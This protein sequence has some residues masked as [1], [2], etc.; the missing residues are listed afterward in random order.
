MLIDSP[1]ILDRSDEREASVD[2]A[3]KYRLSQRAVMTTIATA[4][5]TGAAEHATG[6]NSRW[7]CGA[8]S[9]LS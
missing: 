4:P 5:G 1:R 6:D 7:H 9:C 2:A 3:P 8:K